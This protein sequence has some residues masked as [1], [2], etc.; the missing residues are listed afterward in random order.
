MPV[1]HLRRRG[2]LG[3]SGLSWRLTVDY[4]PYQRVFQVMISTGVIPPIFAPSSGKLVVGHCPKNS[5][6]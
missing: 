5:K 1:G 4:I 6:E 2:E 3:Q